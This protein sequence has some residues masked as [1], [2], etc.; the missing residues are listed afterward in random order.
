MLPRPG[1]ARVDVLVPLHRVLHPVRLLV[2]QT[3]DTRA[4]QVSLDAESEQVVIHRR[5]RD[6]FVALHRERVSLQHGGDLGHLELARV[7]GAAGLLRGVDVRRLRVRVERALEFVRLLE[8]LSDVFE[9]L[10]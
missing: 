1:E 8:R 3:R 7:G 10:G 6:F 4:E 9:M 2:A 5:L